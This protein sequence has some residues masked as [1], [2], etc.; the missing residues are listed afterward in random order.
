VSTDLLKNLSGQSNV[1]V[2]V[3]FA[4]LATSQDVALAQEAATNALAVAQ[5]AGTVKSIVIAGTPSAPDA[6]GAVTLAGIVKSVNGAVPNASGAVTVAVPPPPPTGWFMS[7]ETP[8][9]TVWGG[10][11]YFYP[12]NMAWKSISLPMA[13]TPPYMHLAGPG[14]GQQPFINI[15]VQSGATPSYGFSVASRSFYPPANST[16]LIQVWYAFSTAWALVYDLNTGSVSA[17]QFGNPVF[18]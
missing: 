3:S 17:P 1:V 12:N 15:F 9:N 6:Q 5:G 10:S 4:G 13:G 7:D 2:A 8:E 11:Y 16:W 14:S 18:Y